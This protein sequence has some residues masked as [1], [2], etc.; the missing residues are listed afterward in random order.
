MKNFNKFDFLFLASLALWFGETWYFGWN[1]T[2]INGLEGMLDSLATVGI[3]VGAIGSFL[4]GVSKN[5]KPSVTIN[6]KAE[7]IQEMLAKTKAVEAPEFSGGISAL[8]GGG[9]NVKVEMIGGELPPELGKV[10]KNLFKDGFEIPDIGCAL[11]LEEK[12]PESAKFIAHWEKAHCEEHKTHE[13]TP[14]GPV[15]IKKAP[16]KVKV[17]DENPKPKTRTRKK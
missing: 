5:L 4:Y 14:E 9:K 2:P 15:E 17:R 11:E 8:F 13:C 6:F 3:L 16:V 7:E 10:L 1:A 12:G